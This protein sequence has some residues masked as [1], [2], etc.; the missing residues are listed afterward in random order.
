MGTAWRAVSQMQMRR[1]CVSSLQVN[2]QT[3]RPCSE[4]TTQLASDVT[5][6]CVNQVFAPHRLFTSA[7]NMAV[8]RL[9]TLPFQSAVLT[10]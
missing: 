4:C 3:L 8:Y 6:D 10:V 9:Q 5:H 7:P 2:H 1:A